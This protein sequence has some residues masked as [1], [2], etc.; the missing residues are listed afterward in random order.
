MGIVSPERRGS[1]YDTTGAT[2]RGQDEGRTTEGTANHG[3]ENGGGE[4]L[5]KIRRDRKA[6]RASTAFVGCENLSEFQKGMGLLLKERDFFDE[7][8]VELNG[9]G[10]IDVVDPCS[11]TLHLEGYVEIFEALG[12][13][14]PDLFVCLDDEVG[15]V[16]GNVAIGV[17]IVDA[18][19]D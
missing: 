8:V 5:T 15:V 10:L 3:K 14:D 19:V 1:R 2:E 16:V 18:K 11:E 4:R 12:L 9:L 17:Y 13:N 6:G 7:N